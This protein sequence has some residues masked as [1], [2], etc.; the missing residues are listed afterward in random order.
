MRLRCGTIITVLALLSA[1]CAQQWSIANITTCGLSCLLVTVPEANC[2]FADT[3][4]QCESRILPVLTSACLLEN[5]TMH[6]QLIVAKVQAATCD[7]P[8]PNRSG[9]L[10]ATTAALFAM[11]FL[12]ITLRLISRACASSTIGIDDWII[13]LALVRIKLVDEQ[14][15]LA[16]ADI[17]SSYPSHR[18]PSRFLVRGSAIVVR[19]WLIVLVAN[20]GFG[21]HIWDLADGGLLHILRSLYI[22]ES[23]YVITL[24]ATKISVLLLYLRIFPHR[25]FRI[26]TSAT[27][28]MIALSTT[29]I[30]FM[31]VFSCHPVAF[32][33][34]RDIRSGTCMDVNALAYANSAMSIIQDLLIVILPLPML[35]KLNMGRKKKIGVGFMFAVGSFGCVVSMIR[36]KSLL[37]FGNSLDPSW[38]YVNVVIWT[39]VELAVAM[40]CSCF[41][42]IRNLL[43]RIYPRAFLSSIGHTSDK[44]LAS[45]PLSSNS[46]RRRANHEQEGFV[47]LQQMNESQLSDTPPEVPPKE[48]TMVYTRNE[49]WH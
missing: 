43:I 1:S 16:G 27:I 47:E 5:C 30:F 7:L 23:F 41:P 38:D 17:T 40:V 39:I 37:S 14:I 3:V 48:P 44:Q 49:R 31:T 46:E 11:A 20:E 21:K 35:V 9:G 4:C 28:G 29:I 10:I 6:D 19:N 25:S 2:S 12:A 26:A 18:L 15:S 8:H 42:A 36:L 34:N 33:W 32:F 45:I 22:A 24:A 13:I